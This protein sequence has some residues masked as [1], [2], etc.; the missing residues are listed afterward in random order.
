MKHPPSL[1]SPPAPRLENGKETLS[2]PPCRNSRQPMP[3]PSTH[4]AR[5]RFSPQPRQT[6]RLPPR[7]YSLTTTVLLVAAQQGAQAF[8]PHFAARRGAAPAVVG[9]P[10][11]THDGP[12]GASVPGG[13]GWAL[14]MTPPAASAT[15]SSKV[16]KAV[17][18]WGCG[19][20]GCAGNGWRD[21]SGGRQ[22]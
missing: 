12:V 11:I 7:T 17:W 10:S 13:R 14:M 20:S 18:K 15:T 21:G 16:R 4:R 22:Q 8:V 9:K 6:M 2:T 19:R 3:H 1:T 5:T